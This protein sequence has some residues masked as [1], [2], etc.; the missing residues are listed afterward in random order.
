MKLLAPD[1]IDVVVP[2]GKTRADTTSIARR[3]SAI[4]E[5]EMVITG[6]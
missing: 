5:H 3:T 6:C 2:D 1:Y 4:L